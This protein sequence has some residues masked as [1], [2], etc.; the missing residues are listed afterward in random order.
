MISKI[1][2]KFKLSSG[3]LNVMKLSGGTLIGQALSV[4]TI[5]FATRIY[6]SGIIGDW[7]VMQ[8]TATMVNAFSSLGLLQSVVV[9]DTEEDTNNVMVVVTFLGLI[10]GLIFGVFYLGAHNVLRNVI[11][12]NTDPT[13]AA[14][15]IFI[16]VF[17]LQQVQLSYNYLNKKEQY[18]VLMLNPILNYGVFG[19]LSVI[20]GLLGFTE[21]GYHISWIVGQLV[22][23]I[24]MK[25]FMPK[26][27]WRIG[28]KLIKDVI[29]KNRDFVKYQ[30]PAFAI[31]SI[32]DQVPVFMINIFFGRQVNGYYTMVT[33]ILKIPI[34]FLASAIGRV[35][36]QTLASLKDKKNELISYV[37]RNLNKLLKVAC[38]PMFFLL[39][40]GDIMV[41]IFLGSDW[42]VAGVMLRI[43]ALE[44]MFLFLYQVSYGL[45]I[46]IKKQN[47]TLF[48]NI[49]QLFVYFIS[50]IIGK[51]VFDSVYA[52][53]AI[54]S[55][56]YIICNITF[57]SFMFYYLGLS[58]KGYIK[59]VGKIFISMVV[60]SEV[61]R[62]LLLMLGIVN[63]I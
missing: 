42:E 3:K 40:A 34:T 61:I 9:Q 19:I 14:I 56:G 18:K 6:G 50:F 58:V 12:I 13:F 54:L 37:E 60:L 10:F 24:H 25:R 27:R 36:F 45:P 5:P 7:G 55:F 4:I 53:V 41:E 23:L 20:L 59:N 22:T 49:G 52:S 16:A 2:K 46:V 43:M 11:D 51:F 8:A 47:I 32:K 26:M 48:A 31:A 1:K 62:I 30:F 63:T 21:Y 57:F 28:G 39:V 44:N 15:F 29:M 35:F 33:R 38:I 17:T